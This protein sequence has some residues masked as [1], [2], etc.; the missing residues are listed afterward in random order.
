MNHGIIDI[1]PCVNLPAKY[2]VCDTDTSVFWYE[3]A[4]FLFH[5]LSA[6]RSIKNNPKPVAYLIRY[7]TLT[8]LTRITEKSKNLS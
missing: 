1:K 4:I 6:Q 7:K 8:T 5:I 3:A 2:W